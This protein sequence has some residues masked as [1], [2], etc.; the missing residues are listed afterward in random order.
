M[1]HGRRPGPGVTSRGY[2]GRGARPGAIREIQDPDWVA[3][4]LAVR[5]GVL[6][7][8]TIDRAQTEIVALFAD[9]A[10]TRPGNGRTRLRRT[11]DGREVV[12]RLDPVCD[13]SPTCAAL[14]TDPRVTDVVAEVLGAGPNLFKDK[15]ITKPPGTA[16]YGLHQDFMRWQSF[17]VPADEMVTACLCLDRA[18]ASSGTLE[19]FTDQHHRLLTPPGVTGDPRPGDVDPDRTRMVELEP[20]GILLL[21]PLAPHRSGPNRSHGPRRIL[22]LTYS[23]ARHGDLRSDYYA[24][25]ATI[26]GDALRPSLRGDEPTGH[27]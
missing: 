23:A 15:V 14:A 9:A 27:P 10:L 17:G 3:D 25:H 7:A 21:H 5:G 26:F 19:V 1:G 16:G 22:F 8:E 18:D 20:G 13:I 11:L 24:R 6:D 12:D 2:E 4:G